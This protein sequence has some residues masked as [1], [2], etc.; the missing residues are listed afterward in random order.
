[1]EDWN[2]NNYLRNRI[3]WYKDESTHID[4]RQNRGWDT[5]SQPEARPVTIPRSTYH[6]FLNQGACVVFVSGEIYGGSTNVLDILPDS[7][8]ALCH[9]M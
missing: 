8:T 5:W 9:P 1:M 6:C 3:L 4:M 2:R 7:H